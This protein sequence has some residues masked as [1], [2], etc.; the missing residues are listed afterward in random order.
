MARRRPQSAARSAPGTEA[1]RVA[2]EA[3]R[4][5][6]EDGSYANLLLPKLLAESTLDQRDRNLVT[7]LVYGST[8]MR[9]ACDWLVDRFVV[10]EPPPALRASLRVGAYQLAFTRIP[11]HAAVSA[12]VSASAKRNRAPV[13]A[14]LRKVADAL[15][16]EWPNEGIRLSMPDWL[17]Q[18]LQ[19][20]LGADEARAMLEVMNTPPSVHEREDGYVQDPASQWVTDI[21]AAEEGELVLDLCA[22]PGGKTTALAATGARVVGADLRPGRAGLIA[23]NARR[24]GATTIMSVSADGRAAPFAHGTFDRV[25]VDAPCSGL[26]VLRRRPDAR[27]RVSEANVGELALL[28]SGLLEA[29]V[30]LVRPGG[31]LV[32]SVCTVT[33]AETTAVADRLEAG[34]PELTPVRISL[35]ER[36]RPLGRGVQVLPQDHD[37]DGMSVFAWTVG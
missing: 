14:I 36:W 30:D 13:N 2:I 16:V 4:R 7:E 8:R 22:A 24:L 34:H 15:P 27:W 26:G 3:V 9:R 37:T 28:Q 19:T 10:S 6:D 32:Y 25:L 21:V 18:R 29:A 11:A 17:I 12:T 5:I 1:R 23:E 20:D 35:G 33:E 31:R